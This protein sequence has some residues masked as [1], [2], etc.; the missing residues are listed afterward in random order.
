MSSPLSSTELPELVNSV[1][2]VVPD[3]NGPTSSCAFHP[4]EETKVVEIDPT[5][6]TKT[7]QIG[8]KL[9]AKKES[10]LADFLRANRDVFAWKPSNIPGIPREVAEHALC[11]VLGSKPAKQRLRRFDDERR[12]SI[13]EEIAKLL[14][15]GLIKE[16][17]HFDWLANLVL[18]K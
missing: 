14:A 7:V 4:T 15:A 2:P 16:V 8:T 3:C 13:G 1:T 6:S 9:P 17:Y 12:R 5:D 10:E 18:V 11:V